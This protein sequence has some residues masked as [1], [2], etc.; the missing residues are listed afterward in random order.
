MFDFFFKRSAKKTAST[1][2][3]LQSGQFPQPDNAAAAAA[4]RAR[5]A[6][7]AQVD[8]L[9]GD[10]QAA[11]D[12]ILQ[13]PF[14]DLRLKAAE[15]VQSRQMLER[16]LSAMRNTDR[17]VVK[18]AQARLDALVRQERVEQSAAQCIEQARRLA[19]EPNPMPNRVADLDR[20]WQA[21][22]TPPASSQREFDAA[23]GIL[24]ERLEAQAV[25]QRAVIDASARLRDLA[26]TADRRAPAEIAQALDTLQQEMAQHQAAREAPSL[27]KNLLSEF[28]QNHDGLKRRLAALEK[29]YAALNAREQALTQWEETDIALLKEAALQRAWSD[30]PAAAEGDALDALQVRFDALMNRLVPLR[31]PKQASTPEAKQDARPLFNDALDGLEKALGDGALQLASEHDKTL[32]AIDLKAVRPTDA[33]TARLGRARAE[34]GRLRGWARWGGNVSREELLGAAEELSAKP[35]PVTELAQKVGSLRE[36]WKSLDVS[37]GSAGKELWERFDAACTAAYAPV[38]A[39]FKNLADERQQNLAKAQAMIDEIRQFAATANVENA[40]AADWK[41]IAAFCMRV[42]QAWK[43]LGPI[44]RKDRKRADVEFDAAMQVLAAPLAQQRQVEIQRREQLIDEASRVDAGDRAAPDVLRG[45]QERWQEHAKSLPLERNDEQ[46]LWL[47]FRAACDAV[48]AQRKQAA[49][50]A[51]ADRN[52]NLQAKEALCVTLEAALDTSEAAIRKTLRDVRDAWGMIGP[53]PRAAENRLDARCQAAIAALDGKLDAAKRTA[54][55]AEFD[56]LHAKLMLC[57]M[58]EQ[59]LANDETLPPLADRWQAL[60]ALAADFERT[61]R[62][63][64]DAA[65]NARQSGD[66]G[67]VENLENNRAELSN[68]LLRLEIICGIDSPAQLSRERLQRQVEVLQSSLMAGQKPQT[69]EAQLLQLCALPALADAHTAGRI[70]SVI[71]SLKNGK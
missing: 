48:F 64:F 37:I 38:A 26:Q 18:V 53:V 22:G 42:A 10:E 4:A 71:A 11:V 34:L 57:Q 20:A 55:E 47:R 17:R 16:V 35:L 67:Y 54:L 46:A 5:Q 59:A 32:R 9:H 2:T 25:L 14:A 28:T 31:K 58:M 63:R 62:D 7:L 40:D 23:R 61:L 69:K 29:Q 65:A 51:D 44:D 13:S 43:R 68:E 1:D 49:A 30:L 15:H 24:R 21:I 6:A 45:L 50:V 66:R 8:A 36:R 12:F 70:D 39:H 33:Q 27:P 52:Q 19:E 56:A 3:P 41:A 60:P